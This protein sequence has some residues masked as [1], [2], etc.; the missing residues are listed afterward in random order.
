MVYTNLKYYKMWKLKYTVYEFRLICA[1]TGQIEFFLR[2]EIQPGQNNSH[3]L[4]RLL[5]P[6]SALWADGRLSARWERSFRRWPRPLSPAAERLSIWVAPLRRS[7]GVVAVLAVRF[8]VS[9]TS[10]ALRLLRRCRL[11]ESGSGGPLR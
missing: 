1:V 11:R 3:G 9:A 5:R 10:R 8:P 6:V 4:I 7:Q 2:G